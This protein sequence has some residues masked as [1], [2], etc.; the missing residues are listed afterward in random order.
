MPR[1]R[2]DGLE[3]TLGDAPPDAEREPAAAPRPANDRRPLLVILIVAGL[4]RVGF[5]LWAMDSVPATW[6][7]SGDQYSYWYYGN[8]I[9]D[10]DGYLSYIDG[11]ATSYYPVGYPVTLATLFFLQEHTP[12]PDAQP[13]AVALLQAAMSTASVWFVWLIGR[14]ALGRRGGLIAAAITALFPNLIL[15]TGT[16]SIETAFIFWALGA[17]AILATHDWDAGPPSTLRALAF[18]VVL[19]ASVVTRPFAAPFIAFLA[20]AM[21]VRHMGWK[22]TA[23]AVALAVVPIV[24]AVMPLTI[25]NYRA[26]DAFVP[27]S[28]NLGDTA[29]LDRSMNADG[30]FRW[31]V[32]GCADPGMHEVPRNRENLR[33]AISFIV[34][35]PLKE[36]ELMGKRFGRMVEGDH[37]AL[38]ESESVNGRLVSGTTRNALIHLADAYFWVV[39]ALA[40]VGLV[41]LYRRGARRVPR[42]FV[43]SALLLFLWIPIELWGNVRFHIPALPL[44]AIAAAA[45]PLTFGRGLGADA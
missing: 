20:V 9:A 43:A 7:T 37:S 2:S 10:G 11:S 42:A 18:G 5:G 31:A 22:Q 34:N 39:F 12:I 28:N 13:D 40:G 33:H 16:Y 24:I 32:E 41:G 8:E 15:L 35:H 17:L 29:C 27:I 4:L 36:L 30:G 1:L 3:T 6:Q 14:A 19:A 45:V 26:F 25:R 44:A 23:R 21:L 38:L